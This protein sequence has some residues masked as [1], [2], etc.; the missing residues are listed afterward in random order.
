MK[1][2]AVVLA[3]AA[4]LSPGAQG[5]AADKATKGGTAVVVPADDIKWSDVPGFRQSSRE[6]PPRDRTIHS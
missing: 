6:T 1:K 4:G 5:R 2:V 3:I